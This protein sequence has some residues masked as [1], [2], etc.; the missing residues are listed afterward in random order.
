[1]PQ[2][3]TTACAPRYHPFP[4]TPFSTAGISDADVEEDAAAW[5]AVVPSSVSTPWSA[6]PWVPSPP[7]LPFTPTADPLPESASKGWGTGGWDDDSSTGWGT[8]RGTGGSWAEA[9]GTS[10]GSASATVRTVQS[11]PLNTLATTSGTG[12][13]E[14]RTVDATVRTVQSPPLDT[15]ATTSGAGITETRTTDG[16]GLPS[17]ITTTTTATASS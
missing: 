2:R 12:I 8:G 1:M 4:P 9:S 6:L 14:P 17:S 7:P 5:A 16:H 13:T 15:L 10:V 11:L 3:P